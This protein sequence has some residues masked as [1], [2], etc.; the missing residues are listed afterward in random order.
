M[1]TVTL[2][3]YGLGNIQAFAN[4]Y[5]RLG[6]PVEVAG[7]P[8]QLGRA[9][10]LVL[11]GV[12]S[13]DWAMQRLNDSGLRNLLD[14]LV[15]QHGVPVLGVCVGMQIMAQRSEEGALSGLGWI[16]ADVVRFSPAQ[17]GDMPLPHMGWNDVH[18]VVTDSLFLGI[19]A[20]RY[21]FL[22][23]YCI[24]P[25]RHEDVLAKACYGTD[26]VAAVRNGHIIGTQFHPEKSHQWGI[27]LLRNFVEF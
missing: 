18:P 23:S 20:P 22:H 19:A 17:I 21:Y 8:E 27:D 26:F 12:G 14:R 25:R 4:I 15:L 9:K 10:K 16:D 13:F 7:T 6:M 1:T 2:V 11:P 3:N 24:V 5:R